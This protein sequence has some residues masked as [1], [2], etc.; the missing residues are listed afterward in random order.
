MVIQR[1]STSVF[2]SYRPNCMLYWLTI[3]MYMYWRCNRQRNNSTNAST[4]ALFL[5]QRILF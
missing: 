1:T 3:T 2:S 4:K 5:Y